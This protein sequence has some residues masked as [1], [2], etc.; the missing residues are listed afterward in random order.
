[1]AKYSLTNKAIEDLNDIW[2]Y[3]FETWGEKLADKYYF[4]LL[5]CFQLLCENPNF[6]KNYD[7]IEH[8]LFGFLIRKHVIFYSKIKNDEIVIV[9]ILHSG[10]DLRVRIIE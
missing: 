3:T 6:G 10:M 1:M 7:E 8:K 4:E 2:A 5:D 9:R